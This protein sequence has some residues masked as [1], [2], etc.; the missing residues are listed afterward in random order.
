MELN[1]YKVL[2]SNFRSFEEWH[3]YIL[4]MHNPM[5]NKQLLIVTCDNYET[6]VTYSDLILSL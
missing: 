5:A 6:Y 2:I 1:F 3:N 4:S